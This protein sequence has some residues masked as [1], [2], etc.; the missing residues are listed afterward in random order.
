[1]GS[2]SEQRKYAAN[3]GLSMDDDFVPGSDR[4]YNVAAK[5]GAVV[6]QA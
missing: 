3:F 5:L 6:I 2:A 4:S 1:M